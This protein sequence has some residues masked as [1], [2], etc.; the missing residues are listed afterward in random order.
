MK[1]KPKIKTNRTIITILEPEQAELMLEY[2]LK[3]Q[4]HLLPFEPTRN[5]EFYTLKY[6]ENTLEE[7]CNDF[8]NKTAIKFSALN[9]SQTEVVGVCNFGNIVFGVFCACHLGYSIAKKHEAQGLMKE[10]LE[11]SINYIFTEIELHRIMANYMTNNIRSGKLL[12]KLGFE[13]EGLA[14]SYLKIAGKWEDH[15]LT[16]KINYK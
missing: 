10:I 5:D 14:K 11:A 4:E 13:K 16:S 12:E 2:Y 15:I 6:W 7:N 3:N 8:K 1:Q 9:H